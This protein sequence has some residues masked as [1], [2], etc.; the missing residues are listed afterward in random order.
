MWVLNRGNLISSEVVEFSGDG[1]YIK[2]ISK[3]N[4]ATLHSLMSIYADKKGNLLLTG[5]KPSYNANNY[6]KLKK[7]CT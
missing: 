7:E 4:N 1:T 3:I 6:R 2:T 5:V